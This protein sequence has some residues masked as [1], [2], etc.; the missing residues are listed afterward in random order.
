MKRDCLIY[1]LTMT[2][3][4]IGG[5]QAQSPP[6][7]AVPVTIDNFVRA[8]TDL[9]FGVVVSRGGFGKF[10]HN[11]EL[12]P[13]NQRGVIR[14]NRDTLYSAAVFDLDAGLVTVSLPKAGNRYM[15]MQVIDEDHFT[16][17]AIYGAGSYTFSREKT[18]TRYIEGGVIGG[19][20]RPEF[21]F[22]LN[23]EQE[24]VGIATRIAQFE[25]DLEAGMIAPAGIRVRGNE[26]HHR[27]AEPGN[28]GRAEAVERDAACERGRRM[29]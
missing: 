24:V 27:V 12:V 25:L 4:A 7:S 1:A 26:G 9:Y 21:P 23:L 19:K 28:R 8:E 18:D 10:N 20:D 3:M 14:P 5:A 29:D 16:Q 22:I 17:A 2:L 15:S 6:G 13:I 11:R